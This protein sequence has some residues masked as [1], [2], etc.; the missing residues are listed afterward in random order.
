[1]THARTRS[2]RRAVLIVALAT[3]L[4]LAFAASA[5][6][7]ADIQSSGPLTDLWV[8][9]NLS[10][11]SAHTADSSYEFYGPSSVPGDCGT[12]VA[13]SGVLYGF[14]GSFDWVT[15]SQSPASGAGTAQNPY[16]VETDV[17]AENDSG[18][19]GLA[20]KEV[21]SY[22][23][24]N[25]YYRTD[26]TLTN[27]NA[28]ASLTDLK[29]YHSADCY[30]QGSDTGFGFVDPT[31]G[32]VACTQ[33]PNDSPQALLEEFA[34]LTPG[35]HYDEER[36]S[37]V[38]SNVE[39]TNDL[40]DQCD[41]NGS[42]SNPGVAEDNGMAINWD[43]ASLAPAQSASFSLLSNFSATGVTSFPI[44]AADGNPLSGTAGAP[45]SGNVASFTDPDQG[46]PATAFSATIAWGDGSSSPGTITGA[47]GTFN[48][49]G[50]HTY[51]TAGSYTITVTVSRVSNGSGNAVATDSAV[52]TSTPTTGSTGLGT[53]GVTAAGFS[54]SVV[55]GGLPT[56]ASFQYGLDPKYSGGGPVVYTSSTPA[57]PIGSDYSS[58]PVS[59]SVSGLVPNA[60]YHVRLVAANSAGT[61]FG[62]DSTFATKAAPP[63][64]QP[65]ALGQT[66]NIA[67]VN[68]VVLVKI[69]GVFIPLT[70]LRQIPQN[71]EINALHGTL[72]LITA[73][74]GAPSGAHD[75]TAK[76]KKHK[77][78]VKTQSGTFGGAIFKLN[79]AK[80]GPAKGLVTLTLVENAFNGAPSYSTCKAGRAADANAAALSAKTLQ[81]LHANAKG[82]FST[83]GKYGA[84][85]V[86]GTKWTI[87]DRC[88]GTLTH[89]ITHSVA[90]TDF[91]R[92]K[93]I[94]LHA[95]Q[96]YL[97]KPKK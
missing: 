29:V 59:A 51:A 39:N 15:D 12:T 28:S 1:M 90:V 65:P 52:I 34:P 16:R 14:L 85:T 43:V 86:R 9:D 49:A 44:L 2:L 45:V 38:N 66:F 20:V 8:A 81:L 5:L 73:A 79:Q 69:N 27:T 47:N 48:V 63:P 97:A 6:A 84:A 11:G 71:V 57:Q 24:G 33:T 3:T 4:T 50:S 22:V 21:D 74:G 95:G 62:P 37:T 18:P 42:P 67:P 61:T 32:A 35:S 25:E 31:N 93:T 40:P 55:P 23:V 58:H 96:S 30:L 92:H 83:S 26:I 36:Y 19:I 41:C 87:A 77:A 53:V 70:Q 91:V 13:V 64:S 78:K 46:D 68:G 88:D 82:K 89:D 60:L 17:H 75:A 10:C 80:R 54:A 94:I 56:T 7:Q 76:G 72:Q